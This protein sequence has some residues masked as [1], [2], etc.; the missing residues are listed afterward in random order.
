M[1]YDLR[2]MNF[3]DLVFPKKCVNC[4]R[5]G[6]YICADCSKKIV[7]VDHPICPICQ[8]QAIGGK[9]H[10]GCRGKYKLDGLVAGLRYRGPVRK[11]ISKIKYRFNWDIAETFV[12]L[13]S[14]Q[15]WR[16][17]MPADFILVPIPLHSRRKNWRGFNQAELICQILAKRFKVR[18]QNSLVRTKETKTQVGLSQK[19]RQIN[20]KGALRLAPLRQTQGLKTLA[21]LE[22]S[23]GK[24][25]K[26]F[27]HP[28]ILVDDVFTTGAT[29]FEACNVLKRAGAQEVWA[30]VMALD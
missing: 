12:G 19:D 6:G 16:F 20:I 14:E 29:M 26:L 2:T 23:R 8:R 17:T 11:G 13:M 3:L 27:S 25:G 10:P 28:V 4:G 9:T 15:I 21:P 5:F 1:N 22:Y 30:M 24:Q 18:W 7:V